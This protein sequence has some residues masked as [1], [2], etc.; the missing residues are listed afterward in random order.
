MLWGQSAKPQKK[1][2]VLMEYAFKIAQTQKE[3]CIER[4]LVKIDEL[5]GQTTGNF[6]CPD[7]NCLVPVFPIFPEK[8]KT[9]QSPYFRAGA[10]QGHVDNCL[11]DGALRYEAKDGGSTCGSVVDR[12]QKICSDF[13]VRFIRARVDATE[14]HNGTDGQQGDHLESLGRKHQYSRSN[15]VGHSESKRGSALIRNFA[16]AFEHSPRPLTDMHIEL[17]RCPARPYAAP[18][19]PPS[20]GVPYL[21]LPIIHIYRGHYS[22]HNEYDSGVSIYFNEQVNGKP[23]SVWIAHA[24]GPELIRSELI[25]RLHQAAAGCSAMVYVLGNFIATHGKYAIEVLAINDV[26]VTLT[27]EQS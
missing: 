2:A 20:L 21:G 14:D 15:A 22:H 17:P 5:D 23:L 7:R 19:F 6:V 10:K 16:E 25:T 11:Q 4:R 3:E 12:P 27:D 9:S 26:W 18:F 13:P 1:G 24:L 8:T